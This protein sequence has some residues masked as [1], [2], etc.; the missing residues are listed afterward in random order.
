MAHIDAGKTTTTERILFY[1][2]ITHR[3]GEVHDGAATMDWMVQEQERGITITSAATTCFW[4][5][6]DQDYKVNIIDTPGH[7]AFTN[8]R[9]RG[10]A[11]AD[12]AVLV[13]DINEGIKPQTAEVIQILKLNQTPFIIAL[14]KYVSHHHSRSGKD[15]K[16]SNC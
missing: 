15:D 12:L 16:Y 8:L 7:A 14:N 3:I 4:K 1:T 5:Y 2:G 13:I 6:Q 10:G 9:K 11:L